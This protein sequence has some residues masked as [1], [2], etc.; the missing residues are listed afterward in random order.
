ML[1]YDNLGLRTGG[2]I[3]EFRYESFNSKL[4]LILF[5]YTLVIGCSKKRE[6]FEPR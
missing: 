2:A 5:V 4:R 6:N 3:F 1:G